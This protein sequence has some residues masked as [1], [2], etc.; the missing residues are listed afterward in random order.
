MRWATIWQEPN[1]ERPSHSRILALAAFCVVSF[2]IIKQA[3][4][5]ITQVSVELLLGYLGIM[6]TGEATKSVSRHRMT[7]DRERIRSKV[8][9]P[10]AR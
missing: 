1:E 9:D 2:V 8:D 4:Y 10:D 6:V 7:V 3:L 5:D